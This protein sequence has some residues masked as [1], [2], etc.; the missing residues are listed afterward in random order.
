MHIGSS[1]AEVP[2]KCQSDRIFEI[3][4]S[5]LRYFT[6]SNNKTSYRILERGQGIFW[7]LFKVCMSSMSQRYGFVYFYIPQQPSAERCTLLRLIYTS[8]LLYISKRQVT[9][10]HRTTSKERSVSFHSTCFMIRYKLTVYSLK[11]ITHS[12]N[13]VPN[14]WKI[15]FQLCI[16]LGSHA[17]LFLC[18]ALVNMHM[19]TTVC[20]STYITRVCV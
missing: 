8:Q 11:R 18:A 19:H 17:R 4:I 6:I 5:R 13:C 9:Q 16:C 20:I 7:R 12:W 2:V 14:D 15:R 3:Q 10:C 1:A